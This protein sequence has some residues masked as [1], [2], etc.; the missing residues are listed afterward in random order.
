MPC[1]VLSKP[2][3]LSP[4][5]TPHRRTQE[6]SWEDPRPALL[7]QTD[8]DTFIARRATLRASMKAEA[9]HGGLNAQGALGGGLVE[10][11]DN[12]GGEEEDA[13]G[14]AEEQRREN[15]HPTHSVWRV[16]YSG[17]YGCEYY[18]NAINGEIVWEDPR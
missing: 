13:E 16:K 5:R 11:S 2:L 1:P 10:S 14:E 17:A 8:Y 3:F 6:L 4:P 9:L 7:D 15:H 18:K 12:E